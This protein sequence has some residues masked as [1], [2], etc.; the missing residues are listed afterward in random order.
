MKLS[1]VFTAAAAF[2][3]LAIAIPAEMVTETTSS[4]NRRNDADLLDE[5]FKLTSFNPSFIKTNAEVDVIFSLDDLAALN[6]RFDRE[7]RAEV[8]DGQHILIHHPTTSHVG[9]LS[10]EALDYAQMKLQSGPYAVNNTEVEGTLEARQGTCV[11][12]I[13]VI[14]AQ[15]GD[16]CALCY[17]VFCI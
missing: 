5:A 9:T 16:H 4:L 10:G 12:N 11:H 2:A 7:I 3:N 6:K 15:C 13:C 1:A 8:V 17:P 14:V